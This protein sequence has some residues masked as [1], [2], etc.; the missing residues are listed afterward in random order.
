MAGGGP[1][2]RE[3]PVEVLH[4]VEVPSVDRK[5]DDTKGN[6]GDPHQIQGVVDSAPPGSH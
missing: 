2:P 6:R 4:V 5:P 1:S 3:E